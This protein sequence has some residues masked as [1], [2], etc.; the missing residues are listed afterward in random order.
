MTDETQAV[1]DATVAPATVTVDVP[2][3]VTAVP[4]VTQY[5]EAVAPAAVTAPVT[6]DTD[7]L[8]AKLKEAL[9]FA[10]H[11]VDDVWP[12]VV[13]LAKKLV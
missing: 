3:T 5:A 12:E 10:G 8:L 13:A 11:A 2:V 9:V 6:T 7:A 1:A 4:A